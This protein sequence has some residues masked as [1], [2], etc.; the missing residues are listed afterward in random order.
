M[1]Q[2]AGEALLQI[3][4]LVCSMDIGLLFNAKKFKCI[5]SMTNRSSAMSFEIE[6]YS[7]QNDDEWLHDCI[8]VII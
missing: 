3:T 4:G 8:L 1:Q 2:Q 6:R 5:S 7:V